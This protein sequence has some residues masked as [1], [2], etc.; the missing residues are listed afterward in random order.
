MLAWV[1]KGNN[2][3]A[4]EERPSPVPDENEMAIQVQASGLNR[5]DLLQRRGVYPAPKWAPADILGLEYAGYVSEVGVKVKNWAVGDR[6][7][8]LVGG[9]AMA[10]TVIT[11]AAEVLPIPNNLDFSE[12][13]GLP[14]AQLTAFDALERL[15]LSSGQSLLIHAIGSGVGEALLRQA[16]AK[17]LEVCGTS[18]S[19]WKIDRA[20]ETGL[21]HAALS[22]NGNF[23][24]NLNGKTFDGIIDFIGAAY[25]R[26]N[27]KSMSTNGKMLLLGLMGGV[28]SELDLGRLLR[29][30]GSILS[31]TMRSR[32]QGERIELLNRFRSQIPEQLSICLTPPHI[33][34]V[35][36]YSQLEQAQLIM[37]TNQNYG[38]IILDWTRSI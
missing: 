10:Q 23:L 37:Q 27:L 15:G 18:R 31:A 21:Q 22:T 1:C 38:K 12:A 36:G 8:G 6:V 35:F 13:A 9:G 19:Q 28:K 33:D 30:R 16:I 20:I 34:A 2:S 26:Q 17:G 7:M 25:M 11:H 3:I 4:L 29:I 5:A 14:E 32:P 24:A